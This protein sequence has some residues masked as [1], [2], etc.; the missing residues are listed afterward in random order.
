MNRREFLGTVAGAAITASLQAQSD[1]APNWGG[2][3]IDVHHHWRT[4]VELNTAHMD[5]AG[6]TRALLLTDARADSAAAM[7]PK[8]RFARFTSVNLANPDRLDANID[9]L[10]QA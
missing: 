2:P 3:V 7:M 10:R 9:T 8:D 1:A 6:I 5:G 4:P